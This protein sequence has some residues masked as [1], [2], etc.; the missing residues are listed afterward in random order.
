VRFIASLKLS[1]GK[2]F[3]GWW[4]ALAL[5]FI[6][7]WWGGAIQQGFTVF[8]NPLKTTLGLSALTV[9]LAIQLR[10]VTGL[11]GMMAVG[12]LFDR[13]GPRPLLLA[14]SIL[15]AL[16]WLLLSF[17]NSTLT[18]FIALAVTSV[19]GTAWF[20][21]VGPATVANWFVKQRGR[22]I[23][24]ALAGIGLGGVL[25]PSMVWIEQEW[26]WQ[27]LA[28]VIAAG[29]LLISAPLS[30]LLRHR[31]EQMGLHPDG[32]PP[33]KLAATPGQAKD[34]IT[35][36]DRAARPFRQIIRSPFLWCIVLAQAT[37]S[38]GNQSTMLFFIPHL[39]DDAGISPARAA[40]ALTA[41]GLLG[42]LGQ[43][44][45]GWLS[46]VL[47]K[48]IVLMTSIACAGIGAIGFALV[49]QTW[50]LVLFSL[51]FGLTARTS[52]PVMAAMLADEFGRAN[53]GKVQSVVLSTTNLVGT[54]GSL[55]IAAMYDATHSY[56]TAF[57][58][59]GAITFIGIFFVIASV[60]LSRRAE[61]RQA[62]ARA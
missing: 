59:G 43:P 60:P 22:A 2:I 27:A 46:D 54:F 36:G 40:L 58:I 11:M 45:F 53:Y 5:F 56:V 28:R 62:A 16:G 49:S 31:P 24:F 19:G 61:T 6:N 30:L 1:P 55:G 37:M 3:Y 12:A 4:I 26:G 23:G 14:S 20:A 17:S 57:L 52:F 7:I 38:V 32:I 21:G 42:I 34:D 15:T 41:I 25:V 44:F 35:R 10:S 9:T 39:Q 51:F 8:F 48:R 33:V 18:F 50:H 13:F 29:T 47:S